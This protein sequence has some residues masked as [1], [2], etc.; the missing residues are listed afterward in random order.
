MIGRRLIIHLLMSFFAFSLA[1]CPRLAYIEAYNN[2][3]AD[4]LLNSH[5]EKKTVKPNQSVRISLGYSFQVESEVG[6]W[7]YQRN[8]PHSGSD[9]PYFDGTLRVQINPGGI[10]YALKTNEKAPLSNFTEQPQG[11]P[12]RA[13]EQKG[14]G[15]NGR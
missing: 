8:V 10:I 4:L 15:G 1:G 11:Y 5:G 7:S 3:D 14:D 6:T 9:G 2:T 13:K 12:L